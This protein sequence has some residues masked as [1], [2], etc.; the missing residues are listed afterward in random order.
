MTRAKSMRSYSLPRLR[1]RA[2]F[3]LSRRLIFS[4]HRSL[5][6]FSIVHHRQ[7]PSVLDDEA[8]IKFTLL[9]FAVVPTQTQ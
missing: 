2:R 8:L 9:A 4:T 3:I 7:A 6:A 1:S 5:V